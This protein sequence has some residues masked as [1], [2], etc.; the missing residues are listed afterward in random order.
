MDASYQLLAARYLRKQTRQLLSQIEGVRKADDIEHVHQARVASR[1]L[2]VAQRMFR[3]CL[4]PAKAKTWRKEISCL[5]KGLGSARDK[6][7]QIEFLRR[8]LSELENGEYRPGIARLLLRLEQQRRE[9]HPQVVKAA[10]RLQQSGV[11]KEILAAGGRMLSKLEKRGVSVS[12]PFVFRRTGKR[13]RRRLKKLLQYQDCLDNPQDSR[14]HHQMRIA[15]KRLRY[16]ME[17]CQPA[18]D[19]QLDEFI[20]AVKDLQMFLGEIHDCDVWVEHLTSFIEEERQ[21]TLTYYGHDRS[22]GR[23]KT[24]LEY[25]RRLCQE[26]RDELFRQLVDYW[27]ELER[28]ETWD[29]LRSATR[30]S[31]EPNSFCGSK[32]PSA[33][34]ES[35]D[36]IPAAT[37]PLKPAPER[38][39]CNGQLTRE[40]VKGQAPPAT[41]R[42][43][44]PAKPQ[45]PVG[46]RP[47]CPSRGRR[48]GL[49]Q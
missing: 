35:S 41:E 42:S 5:T 47:S 31:A 48:E 3:D 39:R 36:R 45:D 33:G 44:Q 40:N 12:S 15:G 49:E 13:I 19:G 24:G 25:L 32:R 38:R 17:I 43:I 8:V 9:I 28:L 20:K 11:A 14:R 16:A 23:L 46:A 30:S 21:R 26:R 7:V 37:V 29:R 27:R 6:D 1:R 4:P 2:R 18:Y 10:D 22:F 34:A